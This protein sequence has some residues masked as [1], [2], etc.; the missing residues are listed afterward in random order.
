MVKISLVVILRKH[1]NYIV[2]MNPFSNTVSA[3]TS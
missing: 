3:S 2:N 1:V